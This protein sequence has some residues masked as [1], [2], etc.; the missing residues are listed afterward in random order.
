MKIVAVIA[1]VALLFLA[2]ARNGYARPDERE[3]ESIAELNVGPGGALQLWTSAGN[4][5]RSTDGGE[6]WLGPT[7]SSARP[8]YK[9]GIAS[10]FNA[11][12]PA[13]VFGYF[14]GRNDEHEIAVSTDSGATW[15]HAGSHRLLADVDRDGVLYA[16][17]HGIE[18]SEDD[19]KTWNATAPVVAKATQVTALGSAV[20]ALEQNEFALD[21]LLYRSDD[22]GRHW[23]AIASA[24]FG[25]VKNQT[26]AFVKHRMFAHP[27]GVLYLAGE[28]GLY[29][30]RDGGVHWQRMKFSVAGIEGDNVTLIGLTNNAAFFACN[31]TQRDVDPPYG[32][33]L[34]CRSSDGINL[35]PIGLDLANLYGSGD[36]A[37]A[38]DGTIYLLFTAIPALLSSPDGGKS[39]LAVT[40]E[41]VKNAKGQ[42]IRLAE[43]DLTTAMAQGRLA[44]AG[45]AANRP[46]PAVPAPAN[47][48]AAAV[49]PSSA[50]AARTGGEQSEHTE[51]HGVPIV[52]VLSL[53]AVM[54]AATLFRAILWQRAKPGMFNGSDGKKIELGVLTALAELNRL[55]RKQAS[56]GAVTRALLDNKKI[57]QNDAPIV[58]NVVDA[59]MPNGGEIDDTRNRRTGQSTQEREGNANELPPESPVAHH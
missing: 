2:F 27:A 13:K 29:A 38:P 19:G 49:K 32:K 18:T 24:D 7:H 45:G 55:K 26:R 11:R 47:N 6:R 58:R 36:I 16:V 56:A 53:F 8:L 33:K 5:F 28:T 46:E 10:G 31:L 40:T 42:L 41:G 1:S 3:Y 34:L 35:E 44:I 52:P 15:Q 4:V 59:T 9:L 12:H 30:S 48:P 21:E 14:P 37:I 50:V 25:S 20:Y 43:P 57:D 51:L 23:Q 17:N 39:W 22:H 54:F